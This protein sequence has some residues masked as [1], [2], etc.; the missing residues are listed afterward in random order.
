MLFPVFHFFLC[1]ISRR[2]IFVHICYVTSCLIW[3][4]KE[5]INFSQGTLEKVKGTGVKEKKGEEKKEVLID[6]VKGDSTEGLK[7]GRSDY[8]KDATGSLHRRDA[9][10][11]AG[12][13]IIGNMGFL[14][15]LKGVSTDGLKGVFID[16]LTYVGGGCSL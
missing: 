12:V 13:A 7:S 15:E 14:D 9:G 3:L 16:E 8:V 10:T 5:F 1:R 11:R 6:E 4:S 2:D